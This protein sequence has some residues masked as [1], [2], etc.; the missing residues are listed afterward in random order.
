MS[1]QQH[2]VAWVREHAG[3]YVPL[4]PD[5]EP[6]RIVATSGEAVLLRSADDDRA[7]LASAETVRR[8]YLAE[9]SADNS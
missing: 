3:A 1:P 7:R 4:G 2:A 8:A 5:A 6:W 9:N